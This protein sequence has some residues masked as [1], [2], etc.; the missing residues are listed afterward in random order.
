MPGITLS[1]ISQAEQKEVQKFLEKHKTFPYS[2]GWSKTITTGNFA[3][4]D[5]S[6][7]VKFFSQTFQPKQYL[8]VVAVACNYIITPNT[9]VDIFAVS[10]TYGATAQYT[11][12]TYTQI[13]GQDVYELKS[14][15]GAINDFQVFYPLN[16]WMEPNS[17]IQIIVAAG[18]TTVTANSSS[19]VFQGKVILH[20]IQTQIGA[21]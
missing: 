8:G 18:V 5:G 9:V 10:I 20:T 11:L 13:P 6:S 1:A 7:T 2:F 3:T 17:Q 14:N 21:S 12:G 4:A 15:G 19:N 16:W